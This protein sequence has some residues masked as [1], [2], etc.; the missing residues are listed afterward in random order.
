MD[1]CEEQE[2]FAYVHRS[3][4]R[5]FSGMLAISGDDDQRRKLRRLLADEEASLLALMAQRWGLGD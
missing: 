3:N 5:R 1:E 2:T 4:I